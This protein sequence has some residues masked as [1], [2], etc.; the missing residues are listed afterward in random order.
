M[1]TVLARLEPTLLSLMRLAVALVFVEH[2]TQKLFTFPA[3]PIGVLG[4]GLLLF[5]GILETAGGALLTLGLFTRIAAFFLSGE[6]AVGYWWMHAPESLY[7]LLNG[8]EAMAVYSFVFLYLAAAG[9]GP[10]S[11]DAALKRA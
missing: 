6:M 10:Y 11:L 3:P 1:V 9:G 8:G 5:T 7:P 4:T 2:G